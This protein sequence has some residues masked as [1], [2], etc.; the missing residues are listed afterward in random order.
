MSLKNIGKRFFKTCESR[1]FK[2]QIPI[3]R[4]E[5]KIKTHEKKVEDFYSAGLDADYRKN[6]I[7]EEIHTCKKQSCLAVGIQK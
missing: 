1:L 7:K 3:F 2:E 5:D 4:L 6:K